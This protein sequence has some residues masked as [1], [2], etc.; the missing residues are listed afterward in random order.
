[1]NFSL[2]CFFLCFFSVLYA[3]TN[4][5]SFAVVSFNIRYDEPRDGLNN[6]HNRKAAMVEFLSA[7]GQDQV[8]T[9]LE[10]ALSEPPWIIGIQEGL[11]RQVAYLDSMLPGYAFTGCG[12]DDGKEAG[13][14]C[15]IFYKQSRLTL[16][17]SGTFWLS[18]TPQTP[19]VGWDAALPR[20]C[21]YAQ[22]EIKGTNKKYWVFN[23][24]LDHIGKVAR[25]ESLRLINYMIEKINF[26]RDPVLLL[27]DFNAEPVDVTDIISPDFWTDTRREDTTPTGPEGTFHSFGKEKSVRRIDYI[28]AQKFKVLSSA[29]T[30]FTS[31]IGAFLSDHLAVVSCVSY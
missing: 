11:N 19:S 15:A 7:S 4:Q 8:G 27:G 9:D 12:R 18:E 2:S 23:C 28:F 16:L 6:W 3:Q 29:H 10:G 22:F 14:M 21:T 25:R 17:T 13:E 31:R 1:M 26:R 5:D 20:I 24:H 30:G